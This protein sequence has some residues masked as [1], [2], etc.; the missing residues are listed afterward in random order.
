[1]E[2]CRHFRS[3]NMFVPGGDKQS[4]PEDVASIVS[5]Y[6]WCNKTMTEVGEDDRLVER[7][8]C[9]REARICYRP[10]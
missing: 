6:C 7:E 5:H 1:M 8:D 10:R 4:L 2:L 3:R 9:A